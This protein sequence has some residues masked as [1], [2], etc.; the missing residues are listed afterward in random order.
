MQGPL[1]SITTAFS[2][3]KKEENEQINKQILCRKKQSKKI[4]KLFHRKKKNLFKKFVSNKE[5]T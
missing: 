4:H 3:F 1:S 5:W 2:H